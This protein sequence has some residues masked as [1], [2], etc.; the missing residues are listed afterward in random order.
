MPRPAT[1]LAIAALLLGA[2]RVALAAIPDS[3]GNINSCYPR[4]TGRLTVVTGVGCRPGEGQ[5]SWRQTGLA[6]GRSV[7]VRSSPLTLHYTCTQI[8][9]TGTYTCSAGPTTAVA[10]CHGGER[11]TGGGY[12]KWTN[13]GFASGSAYVSKNTPMPNAAR[14]TGWSVTAS[15]TGFLFAATAPDSTIPVYVVCASP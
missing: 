3:H 4:K 5:L 13:P 12:G 10:R 1:A 2:G 15:S 6:G 7:V 14:P 8:D 9:S 11:A